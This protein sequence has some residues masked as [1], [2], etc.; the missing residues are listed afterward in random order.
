[1]VQ[2]I[3]RERT[4]RCI[5]FGF[6]REFYLYSDAESFINISLLLMLVFYFDRVRCEHVCMHTLFK[7][8]T[9]GVQLKRNAIVHFLFNIV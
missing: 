9:L 5:D 1:V 7:A 8:L 6:Q 3:K 4:F 2:L